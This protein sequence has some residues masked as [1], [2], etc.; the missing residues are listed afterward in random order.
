MEK[1]SKKKIEKTVKIPEGLKVIFDTL[2]KVCIPL[3]KDIGKT[4]T[5]VSDVASE[6]AIQLLPYVLPVKLI[7]VTGYIQHI[8]ENQKLTEEQILTL[9][10]SV[11]YYIT[12]D[13]KKKKSA[14]TKLMITCPHCSKVFNLKS[15]DKKRIKIKK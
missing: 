10:K 8:T 2:D 11:N 7:N 3:V 14:G 5:T 9:A 12:S 1:K 15:A 13:E 6:L 4:L